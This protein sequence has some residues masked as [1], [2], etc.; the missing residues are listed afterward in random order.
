MLAAGIP[1]LPPRLAISLGVS[2]A[3]SLYTYIRTC[4]YTYRRPQPAGYE[5]GVQPAE[6]RRY[7]SQTIGTSG[8]GHAIAS[9]L[10]PRALVSVNH[11]TTNRLDL[12][13][14]LRLLSD[15]DLDLDLRTGGRPF[16]VLYPEY[17]CTPTYLLSSRRG[18][19]VEVGTDTRWY[20]IGRARTMAR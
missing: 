2:T 6:T 8:H 18:V 5:Y 3:R 19:R 4:M 11:I 16:S 14:S 15:L 1:C 13:L 17:P 7:Y 10:K 20:G 12:A 9:I